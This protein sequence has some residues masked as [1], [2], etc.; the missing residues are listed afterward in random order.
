MIEALLPDGSEDEEVEA[1]PDPVASLPATEI[2]D[3][4]SQYTYKTQLVALSEP[5]T[6]IH[7][8]DCLNATF[9]ECLRE[10]N[11]VMLTREEVSQELTEAYP[12]GMVPN[13]VFIHIGHSLTFCLNKRHCMES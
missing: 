9:V 13:L 4:S 6:L 10:M 1:S 8:I 3:W 12:H 2:E 11:L 7:K 5:R